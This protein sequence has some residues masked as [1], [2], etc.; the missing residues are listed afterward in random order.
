MAKKSVIG[1]YAFLHAIIPLDGWALVTRDDGE[2]NWHIAWTDIF[3]TK[4]QAIAFA[5]ENNWNKPW[6]AVP[7][8]LSIIIR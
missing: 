8:S 3:S 7:A 6:R 4:R 2:K 1:R 5:T